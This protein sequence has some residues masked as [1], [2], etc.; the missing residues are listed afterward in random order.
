MK[1]YLPKWYDVE[2]VTSKVN[3]EYIESRNFVDNKRDQFEDW[4][5]AYRDVESVS[6]PDLKM[7]IHLCHQHIKAFMST[8]YNKEY[9]AKFTPRDYFD[10]E[11]SRKLNKLAEYDAE[12]MKKDRKDVKWLW[13]IA[14]YGV[15][16]RIRTNWNKHNKTIEYRNINPLFWY[17]DPNWDNIDGFDYHGFEVIT[18]KE[19]LR[20]KAANSEKYFN[21]EDVTA[22]ENEATSTFDNIQQT[23]AGVWSSHTPDKV[24]LYHHYTSFN[25][26]KYHIVLANNRKLVIKCDEIEAITEEEKKNPRNVPFPVN[27]TNVFPIDGDPFGVSYMELILDYQRAKNRLMNLALYKEERNAGFGVYLYD[28]SKINNANQLEERNP[29]WPAFVPADWMDWWIAWAVQ[30]I[31]EERVDWN[32]LNIADKIDM[33]AAWETNMTASNR[34]LP[35]WPDT[36]LGEA[37]MQQINS[38]LIFSLD[39]QIISMWEEDFWKDM[40]YRSLIE[41]ISATEKKKARLWTG[42]SWVIVQIEWKDLRNWEDPDLKVVSMKEKKER[43][44]KKLQMYLSREP[45]IM[46]DP[47]IPQI[48]KILFQREVM[49][50]AWVEE[51]RVMLYHK[52]TPDERRAIRY[53]K[54]I[55][56]WV[57][58]K[59]MFKPWIDLYTYWIYIQKAEDSDLKEKVLWEVEDQM[60]KE[61]LSTQNAVAPDQ[62]LKGMANSMWSQMTSNLIKQQGEWE[63]LPTRKDASQWA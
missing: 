46:Q 25:W 41:F 7:K 51:E 59:N 26:K 31:Q 55:N 12:I 30:P 10:E 36:T 48:S 33:E 34:W 57:K 16:L 40:R 9:R 63:N 8:H 21:I 29:N 61:W 47:N 17:P 35:Y 18:T 45:L 56:E 4:L 39:S 27:V 32:T 50:L 20:K 15:W 52:L 13:N 54:L 14:F 2:Q 42:L 37:K 49:R 23:S 38:N 58:P 3:T 43:D 5:E 62:W 22:W 6:D 1:K 60:L 53:T 44:K 24:I 11:K 28:K 19:K